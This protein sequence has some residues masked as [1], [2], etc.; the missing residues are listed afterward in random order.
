MLDFS[1]LFY[2]N[3]NF[4]FPFLCHGLLMFTLFL[5]ILEQGIAT[6]CLR[7]TS[8]KERG[9]Q[10]TQII[11]VVVQGHK[12]ETTISMVKGGPL[13]GLG[14][15]PRA[16]PLKTLLHYDFP[17]PT[18]DSL[19]CPELTEPSKFCHPHLT[20]EPS[21]PNTKRSS[22]QLRSPSTDPKFPSGWPREATPQHNGGD[23]LAGSP[24][25][26]RSSS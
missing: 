14:S 11:L 25:H 6:E 12:E 2:L 15:S 26:S 8:L 4:I 9:Q 3:F 7:N 10:K 19:P 13:T 5:I 23:L 16:F 1:F 20:K 24:E 21:T 17:T 18:E 22:D